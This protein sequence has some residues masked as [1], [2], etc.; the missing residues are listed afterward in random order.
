MIKTGGIN[1][2]PV[3]VE[4]V[5][6]SHPG[7]EQA[8]VVGLPDAERDEIVVAVVVPREPSGVEADALRA[9]CAS[10]LAAY[11]RPRRYR[12]V[13][14]EELPLTTTGKV[15]KLGMGALFAGGAGG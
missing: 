11:K 8:Y 2:A 1:V 14:A 6:M 5:L 9:H 7:V 15:R 4:E 10:A 13:A 12:L 3:E